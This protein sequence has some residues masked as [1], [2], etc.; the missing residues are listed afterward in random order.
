MK[1]RISRCP[2]CFII[3]AL[4]VRGLACLSLLLIV[5]ANTEATAQVPRGEQRVA[6]ARDLSFTMSPPWQLV[7]ERRDW[8]NE[9]QITN[10]AGLLVA[11]AVINRENQKTAERARQRLLVTAGPAQR[12]GELFLFQGWPSYRNSTS[13]RL[14]NRRGELTDTPYR[15]HVLAIAAGSVFISIDVSDFSNGGEAAS[16][17]PALLDS[18]VVPNAPDPKASERELGVIRDLR[19]KPWGDVNPIKL[20]LSGIRDIERLR[21]RGFKPAVLAVRGAGELEITAS[22]SGRNVVIGTNSGYARSTDFGATFTP[23]AGATPF[24]PGAVATP[25]L[26]IQT[27]GDPSTA[28]GVTGSFYLFYLGNPSGGG[29]GANSF[30][31]CTVPVAASS[32]GGVTWNFRGDAR[33]CSSNLSA[34]SNC[35]P[36]QEHIAA[37]ARNLGRRR[38]I[39]RRGDQVY[40]IWREFSSTLAPGSPTTC[41]GLTALG[42]AATRVSRAACSRDGGRTWTVAPIVSTAPTFDYAKIT[43][44]RDGRVY[45][46][47]ALAKSDGWTEIWVDQFSSCND[48][49]NRQSGF[50][51]VV[52]WYQTPGCPVGLDRC[53]NMGSPTIAVSPD[54]GDLVWIAASFPSN[55]NDDRV[56]VALSTGGG[57]F[58]GWRE[59]SDSVPGRKFMPWI[60]VTGK[61][62]FASWY[63]RRPSNGNG[64]DNSLTDFYLGR[65]DFELGGPK[66]SANIN[67]SVNADSHCSSGWPSGTRVT[68]SAT[69]CTIQPQAYGICTNLAVTAGNCQPGAAAATCPPNYI[70][71]AQNNGVPKYGDYSGLGCAGGYAFAAWTTATAPTAGA[72]AGLNVWVRPYQADLQGRPF[73]KWRSQTAVQ[74]YWKGP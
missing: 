74:Q 63:D 10:D 38:A 51:H 32:D 14:R 43:V 67:M 19:T 49:F 11:R 15:H 7:G 46:V 39:G 50:P 35:F 70:C 52:G 61:H 60:C 27:R 64:T 9:L 1:K 71:V 21:D 4:V 54:F 48:G 73:S 45:A 36:D 34:T 59:I 5:L 53:S 47:S 66:V 42:A 56:I 16:A 2:Q 62:L 37:D 69:S 29:T 55:A 6:M 58:S 30:N 57:D 17:V 24:S 22:P 72:A 8:V 44:G 18:V 31:G 13:E 25:S 65:M 23:G 20:P 41:S 33:Q 68:S 40:A 12:E 3:N 28:Y 26:G